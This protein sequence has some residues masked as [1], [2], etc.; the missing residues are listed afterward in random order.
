MGEAVT[1][2]AGETS[3][4]SIPKINLCTRRR[5]PLLCLLLPG[6]SAPHSSRSQ[7]KRHAKKPSRASILQNTCTMQM[8]SYYQGVAIAKWSM[9][10]NVSDKDVRKVP[11]CVMMSKQ[12]DS[13]STIED[14]QSSTVNRLRS[15]SVTKT[16]FTTD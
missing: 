12:S 2:Q 5:W 11:S 9:P 10:R 7:H 6:P 3:R 16:R 15:V 4:C 1:P 8:G 13:Q 14:S